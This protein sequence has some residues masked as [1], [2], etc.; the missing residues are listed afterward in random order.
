MCWVLQ[1]GSKSVRAG[2]ERTQKEDQHF[3]NG[4]TYKSWGFKGKL[5]KEG[6]G[7]ERGDQFI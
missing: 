7:R 3:N 2:V 4:D 6:K 1:K 5:R